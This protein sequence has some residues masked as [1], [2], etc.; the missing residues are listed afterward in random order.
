MVHWASYITARV[1]WQ[2][3]MYLMLVPQKDWI[4]C[5]TDSFVVPAKYK[6]LFKKFIGEDYGEL[7]LEGELK[8]FIINAPKTYRGIT[9]QGKNKDAAKGMPKYS[10]AIAWRDGKA[11]FEGSI[12]LYSTMKGRLLNKETGKHTRS[13][14]RRLSGPTSVRCGSYVEGVWTPRQICASF[15]PASVHVDIPKSV[16]ERLQELHP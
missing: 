2:L 6:K 9:N 5:D 4:Y 12:S 10:A 1:R 11:V 14:E 7:K 13:I 8:E 15:D 16:R 3:M